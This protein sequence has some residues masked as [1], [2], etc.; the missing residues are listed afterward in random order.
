MALQPDN[1]IS[2]QNSSG[3]ILRVKDDR[4]GINSV[5]PRSELDVRGNIIVSGISTFTGN[6]SFASTVTFGDHD[7]IR[8]GDGQD[9]DIYHDSNNSV[10]DNHTGHLY[11]RNNADDSDV[12]LLT[13]NSSGGSTIYVQCDGSTGEVGLRHY[14][15][16]KLATKST[17]V[18]VTGTLAATAVTGDGSGLTSLTGASAGTYGASTNTPIITV[19]SNGRITGI[20]TVATSGAG[21]G[22]GISNIVEDTTPQLGGNLDL[23]SKSITGTGNI[24]ITG[25]AAVSGVTTFS[26]VAGFSSH[27][28]L[29]DHAEIQ[30]GDATGGDLRIYHNASDS[31]VRDSGQGGLYLTGS[32]VGI[33]NAAANETGLLFT[34]NGAVQLYHDNALRLKTTGTGVEITDD[35]NVAG[36]STFQSTVTFQSS[37]NLGELDKINFYTT[38]TKIYGNSNGLILESAGNNDIRLSSNSSGS[39]NG[40]IIINTIEGGYLI[41]KGEMVLK[42]HHNGT[43]DKK[44]ETTST[45]MVV[46]GILTATSF[47]G[48]GSAL[49]NLPASGVLT[50]FT[51]VQVT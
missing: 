15:T 16:Q 12:Y 19:D 11:I 14:G 18:S 32:T 28:T 34:E 13:D 6:V 45:G 33:K 25:Y 49:T 20:S 36:V 41:A 7:R 3:S 38:N 4:V 39:D 21:G 8:L 47:V 17:G 22:G 24:D 29:P 2:L 5:T 44:F 48:D 42:I 43:S 46:T 50:A 23:N 40:D 30:V 10:I 9:L 1:E 37:V 35:L 26:G 27:I 51:N 31:Y